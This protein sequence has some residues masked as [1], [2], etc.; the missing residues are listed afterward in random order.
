MLNDYFQIFMC[1]GK[2]INIYVTLVYESNVLLNIG[3]KTY[4]MY[5]CICIS[6]PLLTVV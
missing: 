5:M 2:Q 1:L 3:I 4:T 6:V